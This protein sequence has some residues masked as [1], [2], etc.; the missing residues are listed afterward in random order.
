MRVPA[1][2]PLA[3]SAEKADARPLAQ[4][5]EAF[6]LGKR[7]A[8]CTER[9]VDTYS[10]WLRRLLAETPEVTPLSVRGFFTRLQ[11]GGASQSRQHQAYRTFKI[12]FRWSLEA[13]VLAENPLRAFT[14][15][16]PET[17]PGVPTEDELRAVLAACP[18]TL[19]GVRNRALILVMADAGLRA[20]E[21]LRLLVEDWRAADRGL[22]VRAGKGRRDRVAFIEPTTT[23]ALKAWLARRPAPAPESFLF[24]DRSGRPLKPRHLVQ[25]LHRLSA[26]TGL[27][28]H[29]RLHPHAL[30]HFA[31][32]SWLRAGMGLDEVR[33]LLGDQSLVTTLPTAT[34]SGRPSAGAPQDRSHR[35]APAGLREGARG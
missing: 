19:E 18:E 12:F 34:W 28:P 6:L 7:A 11:E 20:S 9:T 35:T 29:R 21:V 16:T 24:V 1:V 4:A 2:S 27:P 31:A 17:L 23:R 13:G 25:I 26:K 33:R 15:R 14:M 3:E 30:R 22:F 32:T 8:G 5:G 10:W